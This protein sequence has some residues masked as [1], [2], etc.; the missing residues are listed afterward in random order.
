[1]TT[2]LE[3]PTTFTQVQGNVPWMINQPGL[4]YP[5]EMVRAQH[6]DATS[7]GN[8]VSTPESMKV[9]AQP[10]PDGTV[11]IATGGATLRSNYV[12]QNNQSYQVMNFTPQTLVVPPTGS[13]SSGRHDLLI[14]RVIDPDHDE[15]L[16]DDI[17]AEEAPTLD[18]WRYELHQGRDRRTEFPFP[19]VKLAHIRR[20]P[21]QTIVRP[22]DIHDLRKLAAP[23][24]WLHMRS[25]NLYMSEEQSLHT[26]STV[27]P[28]TATHSVD[29]PEW[30]E[31]V[32]IY[33]AWGTIRSSHLSSGVARGTTQVALINSKGKEIITQQSSWR[34]SGGERRERFNIVLGDD[35]KIPASFRGDTVRVELR[36]VKDDGPN[37]Y[38]DGDSTWTLQLYF[39][40]DIN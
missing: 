35:I 7:G 29:I 20:G 2:T 9:I 33:A 8:G 14:C 30:A 27:W 28:T 10:A 40:Q 4:E 39:N 19:H 25:A 22:E 13:A 36:G 3:E 17:S 24:T 5:A 32:Q 1:M 11:Q 23:K 26:G 37:I 21:N 12:G 38:M 34:Y 31:E 16:G 18:F 6:Y 15:T